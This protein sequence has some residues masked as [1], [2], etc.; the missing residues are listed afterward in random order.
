MNLNLRDRETDVEMED[1]FFICN[2]FLGSTILKECQFYRISIMWL[3]R[4][5]NYTPEQFNQ[6]QRGVDFDE[7]ILQRLSRDVVDDLCATLG[8]HRG[9][10][11]NLYVDKEILY[12]RY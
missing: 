3:R 12:V 5:R 11:L 4:I 6:P 1:F 10:I 9:F 2:W 7:G 8:R